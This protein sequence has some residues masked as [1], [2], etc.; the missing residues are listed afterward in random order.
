MMESYGRLVGAT[1]ESFFDDL[2]NWNRAKP[3]GSSSLYM[4]VRRRVDLVC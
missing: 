3:F 1:D 2:V 4:M